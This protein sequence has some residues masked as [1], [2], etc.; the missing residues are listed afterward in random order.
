MQLSTFKYEMQS[1]KTKKL[2]VKQAFLYIFLC[3]CCDMLGGAAG[4]VAA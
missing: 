2:L 1:T 3:V 4:Y